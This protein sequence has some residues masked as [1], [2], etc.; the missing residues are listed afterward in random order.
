MGK[1]AYKLKIP[2]SSA[3]I[4][5]GFDVLGIGLQLY[6]EIKVTIDEEVDTSSDEHQCIIQY[7]G[8]GQDK[9]H[10]QSNRNLVTMTALYVLRTR[11]IE[12]FPPGTHL[13][14]NNPIPLGRGLGSSAAAIVGGVLLANEIGGL[15]MSKERMMDYC[16]MI[17][18]HPDNLAAAMLGGF[19]GS[20]LNE[21]P[22]GENDAKNISMESILPVAG[23]TPSEKYSRDQPPK[24]IG[25]YVKYK[26]NPK[27]KCIAVIPQFELS[28]DKARDAL[29]S[30][31]S[32]SDIVFNLQRLAILTTALTQEE[33]DHKL[34]FEA[35]KDKLHQPYRASLIP[36][37]TKVL[38]SITPET[39][40]S[41][42]GICL[43]GAGPTILCLA[44][45][46][47]ETIAKEIISI[48]SKE[49]I[50]CDWK[51]LDVAY[52]GISKEEC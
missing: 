17:E 16:L 11:G 40:S 9:M 4:G 50:V 35:M 33:V 34:I 42:C 12:K 29:P 1:V 38:T 25:V 14:I 31:Y 43:S 8:E 7:E 19:V 36:G 3:N 48:F 24:D 21:L 20:Y 18:R 37:L 45:S 26:W 6:L 22:A 28:T 15:Q 13:S 32:R 2:A 51:L 23:K 49:G 5:P 27:I 46:E 39:F 10:L 52:D 44:T 30:S 41:V 47:F